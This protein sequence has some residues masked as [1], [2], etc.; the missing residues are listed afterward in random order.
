[1]CLLYESCIWIGWL[2][3]RRQLKQIAG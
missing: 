2:M 1:M 3:E